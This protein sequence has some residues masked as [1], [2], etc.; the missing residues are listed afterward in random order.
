MPPTVKKWVT[1]LYTM[2]N[3]NNDKSVLD[4]STDNN[5]FIIKDYNKFVSPNGILSKYY[6]RAKSYS[7]FIRSLSYYNFVMDLVLSSSNVK[8]YSHVDKLFHKNCHDNLSLIIRKPTI[9][10]KHKVIDALSSIKKKR[11]RSDNKTKNKPK[12]KKIKQEKKEEV[13]EVD[14]V[15]EVE[16]VEEEDY[17]SSSDSEDININ[18]E[19]SNAISP[20]PIEITE[21]EYQNGLIEDYAN[22]DDEE[23]INH[24]QPTLN[25]NSDATVAE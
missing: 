20:I 16:E 7:S 23:E 8:V 11:V 21:Q 4:W 1:Q 13:E 2:V 18:L 25:Y 12:S 3:D 10:T 24:T 5:G 17:Y 9:D 22:E 19:R 15:D 14:E 6:P